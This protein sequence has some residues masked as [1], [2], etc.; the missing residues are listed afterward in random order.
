MTNIELIREL[1]ELTSAGMKNCKDA[2]EEANWDLQKAI[3]IIKIKGQT[4]ASNN[5]VAA[6][7][8]IGMCNNVSLN[9]DKREQSLCMVEVNCNTD[10][11]A[12]SKEFLDFIGLAIESLSMQNILCKDIPW[13]PADAP[14][15]ERERAQLSFT[16]KENIVVRRWLVEETQN[17]NARI[18]EYLHNNKKIGVALTM[19]A[20]SK[21]IADDNL[22][23]ELGNNIAMQVAA[24][25]PIAVSSD[26]ISPNEIERQRAIFET[27]VKDLNKPAE[28]KQKI[29]D[30]KLNKWYEQVCLLDQ[31][32]VIVPKK[33]IH[34][35]VEDL[36]KKLGGEITI[37]NFY[38]YQ[39]GEG[40]EKKEDNFANDAIQ[41]ASV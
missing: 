14:R 10:F 35:L 31:E 21:K 5:K 32:S 8:A 25:C 23:S 29:V 3:D 4:I 13:Q 16:T 40:I 15:V 28:T 17:P 11:V 20:P 37:V 30:G 24:M 9:V 18:F 12:N 26:R 6:E 27:Q 22:F 1:R 36:G 7:G 34:Q 2:L 19:L 38:R 41:M 33:S 39:V